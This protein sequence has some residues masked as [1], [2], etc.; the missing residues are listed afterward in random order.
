MFVFFRRER[1]SS[2]PAGLTRVDL[3][4]PQTCQLMCNGLPVHCIPQTTFVQARR[5]CFSFFWHVHEVGSLI[6]RIVLEFSSEPPRM[7]GARG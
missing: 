4:V 6:D 5:C 2:V 3:F 1:T 7:L